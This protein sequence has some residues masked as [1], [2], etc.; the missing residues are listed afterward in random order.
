MR[1]PTFLTALVLVALMAAVTA[2]ALATC[3]T[4]SQNPSYTV[5]VCLSPDVV[6]VGQTETLMESARNNTST[7]K[8]V[9]VTETVTL[10]SGRQFTKSFYAVLAP[11]KTYSFTAS[12]QINEYF[13]KGTYSVTL[14]VADQA[15]A[16][17][18]TGSFTVN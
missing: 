10:P 2:P 17:S 11:M 18:A 3:G 8:R 1:K 5:M 4:G 15:G 16:S 12:Y 9:L 7:Y 6:T 13:P 14:S